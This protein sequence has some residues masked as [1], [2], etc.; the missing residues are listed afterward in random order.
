MDKSINY[1]RFAGLKIKKSYLKYLSKPQVAAQLILLRL[2][3]VPLSLWI[4][5]FIFQRI[6]RLNSNVPFQVHFTSTVT[7]GKGIFIGRNVWK[8]FALSCGCYIQGGNGI[9][10]GNNT[11]FAPGVKIISANHDIEDFTVWKTSPPIRIG[12]RCWIGSNVVILPGVVIGDNSIVGAGAVVTKSIPPRS[13]AIGN[14]AKII[15]RI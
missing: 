9:Y 1:V 8:S 11:I 5:N 7:I 4:I 6:F 13:V 14:P 3:G 10:I 2:I 12:E 15:R